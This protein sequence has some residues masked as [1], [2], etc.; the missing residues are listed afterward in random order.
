MDVTMYDKG[1]DTIM[2][3]T[4][5]LMQ[6]RCPWSYQ[7]LLQQY[8]SSRCQIPL[9]FLPTQGLTN[10]LATRGLSSMLNQANRK[11]C[12]PNA[13]QTSVWSILGCQSIFQTPSLNCHCNSKESSQKQNGNLSLEEVAVRLANENGYLSW[14]RNGYLATAVGVAMQAEAKMPL[15]G[16][17]SEVLF[18]I[19]GANLTIGCAIFIFNV[20]KLH[21]QIGLSQ[22]GVYCAI[23]LSVVHVILW[24]FAFLTFKGYIT[25]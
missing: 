9:G 25:K 11:P 1:C 4:R 19:A 5:Q 20:W 12:S 24:F 15:S 14:N 8:S 21:P 16:V 6:F 10:C 3:L 17:A 2:K 22:T 18:S 23:L 7:K 13:H